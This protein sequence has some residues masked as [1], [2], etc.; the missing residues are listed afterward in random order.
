GWQKPRALCRRAHPYIDP[1][2]SLLQSDLRFA[3]VQ[4]RPRLL[5]FDDDLWDTAVKL[6][7]QLG[8]SDQRQTVYAEALSVALACELIRVNESGLP[9]VTRIRGGLPGWQQ[10]RA[11]PYIGQHHC[12]DRS[13]SVLFRPVIPRPHPFLP[14]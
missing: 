5:F 14:S 2:I 3:E 11:G 8:S 4:F 12:E 10:K 9:S 6:R 1:R 13:P 7:A